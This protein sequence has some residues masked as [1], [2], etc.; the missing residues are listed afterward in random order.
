[1]KLYLMA[2]TEM[3]QLAILALPAK[4]RIKCAQ[5]SGTR[6]AE[7]PL[8]RGHLYFAEKGTFLLCLDSQD[9]IHSSGLSY[10]S[11]SSYNSMSKDEE[12][13]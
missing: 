2:Q 6:S 8:K 9:C 12:K 5:Q 3:D 1:M 11:H 4:D 13:I 10:P 7:Q